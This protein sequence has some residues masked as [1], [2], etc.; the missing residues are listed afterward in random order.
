[1]TFTCEI[2]TTYSITYKRFICIKNISLYK[3]FVICTYAHTS[4]WTGEPLCDT[5]KSIYSTLEYDG[6]LTCCI[7][8][9][10]QM[11]ILF[12]FIRNMNLQNILRIDNT[13]RLAKECH[14]VSKLY[15]C[16]KCNGNDGSPSSG[17]KYHIAAIAILDH[18]SPTCTCETT[19]HFSNS[20]KPSAPTSVRCKPWRYVTIPSRGI[21][22]MRRW[23]VFIKNICP[24]SIQG[25]AMMERC[26]DGVKLVFQISNT[27][28]LGWHY[29][30]VGMCKFPR[31]Y[32]CRQKLTVDLWTS[33]AGVFIESQ[34]RSIDQK[35][36]D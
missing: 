10:H 13:R 21:L 24:Y 16:T 7:R 11:Q 27:D 2:Y 26:D 34:S 28:A 9:S 25:T 14:Q 20:H 30:A 6:R 12:S 33:W 36:T 22:L 8:F 1:M 5:L 29:A 19:S 4:C 18:F 15:K 17:T 23:D 3:T 32:I 31:I 35:F